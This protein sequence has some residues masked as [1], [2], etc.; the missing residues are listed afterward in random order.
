MT[1][2]G[3]YLD[4]I[5]FETTSQERSGTVLETVIGHLT[6]CEQDHR[7]SCQIALRCI[8]EQCT[9][10]WISMLYSSAL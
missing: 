1:F 10:M 8:K 6:H 4:H 7:N 5:L 2:A 3:L 9:I